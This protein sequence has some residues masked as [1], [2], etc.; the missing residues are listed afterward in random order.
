MAPCDDG[1]AAAPDPRQVDCPHCDAPA[2]EPCISQT[3][4]GGLLG[5]GRRHHPMRIRFART[6]KVPFRMWLRRELR[7]AAGRAVTK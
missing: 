4:R 6:G 1:M 2:G 5:R 3:R 7:K